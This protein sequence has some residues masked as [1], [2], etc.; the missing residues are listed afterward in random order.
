MLSLGLFIYGWSFN[1]SSLE[2][3]L[4]EVEMQLEENHF[5]EAISIATEALD[6]TNDE[7]LIPYFLF[8]RSFAYIQEGEYTDAA[9]DLEEAVQYDHRLP[10]M[11]NN[12]AV[13]YSRQGAN[14]AEIEAIIDEGLS[15]FPDDEELSKLKDDLQPY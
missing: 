3:K 7:T 5:N 14:T 6:D 1:S 12:L 8:H 10:Q 2:L 15:H 11:Y 4:I 9:E 13:L